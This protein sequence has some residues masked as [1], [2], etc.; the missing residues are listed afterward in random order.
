MQSC[1]KLAPEQP[2]TYTHNQQIKTNTSRHKQHKT[3]YLKPLG[4]ITIASL[5]VISAI[6]LGC[7]YPQAG[8]GSVFLIIVA[9][10][11]LSSKEI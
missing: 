7:I 3:Y 10:V 11:R 6:I 9:L 2:I 5:F 4:R 1:R 8:E